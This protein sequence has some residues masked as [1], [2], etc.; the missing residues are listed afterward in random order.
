M[1]V[2]QRDTRAEAQRNPSVRYRLSPAFGTAGDTLSETSRGSRGNRQ[3]DIR[4]R[5]VAASEKD[6]GDDENRA[7]KQQ[8]ERE[9]PALNENASS[10]RTCPNDVKDSCLLHNGCTE[11]LNLRLLQSGACRITD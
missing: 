1:R 3:S 4:T 7:E 5:I 6:P 2:T 11:K 8:P 9:F 10:D